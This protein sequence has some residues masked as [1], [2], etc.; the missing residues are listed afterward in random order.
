MFDLVGEKPKR[1]RGWTFVV[2][3]VLNAGVIGALVLSSFWK[4]EE[5][6]RQRSVGAGVDHRALA[7]APPGSPSV[8][9]VKDPPRKKIVAKIDTTISQPV[10]V[11]HPTPTSS[12]V[13]PS[14]TTPGDNGPPEGVTGGTDPNGPPGLPP[15][16]DPTPQSEPAAAPKAVPI[17]AV[18]AYRISGERQITLPSATK[19][20]MVGQGLRQTTAIV[21]L[22]LSPGGVP[23]RVDVVKGTGFPEADEHLREEISAWRYR[24]L[25]V[26]G[27]PTA[28]CTAV[29]F[30]YSLE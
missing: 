4:I 25:L 16:H 26:N 6:P 7:A 15:S 8:A 13:S 27:A 23:T 29:T 30:H 22:C 9:A 24:P 5:G 17:D 10:A 11:S 21:K 28:V 18:E 1:A 2:S 12:S 3:A 14:T 19:Q 20:A